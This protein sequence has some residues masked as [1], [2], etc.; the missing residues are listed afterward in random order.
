MLSRGHFISTNA[1]PRQTQLRISGPAGANGT[2]GTEIIT[3]TGAPTSSTPGTAGS[4]YVDTSTKNWY[5]P[6]D[7]VAGYP[8]TILF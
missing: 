4:Y 7:P 1:R 5:G 3:G 2:S 6:K 8:G